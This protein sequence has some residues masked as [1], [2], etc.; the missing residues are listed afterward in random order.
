METPEHGATAAE[1]DRILAHAGL[2][3]SDQERTRLIALYPTLRAMSRQLR[4]P[5]ARYAEPALVFRPA[6]AR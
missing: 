3:V 5:Q 2:R 1:V 4:L 6:S